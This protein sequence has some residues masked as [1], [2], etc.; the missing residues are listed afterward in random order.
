VKT[1]KK[2]GA[3]RFR[4]LVRVGKKKKNRRTVNGEKRKE[5]YGNKSWGH[6]IGVGWGSANH[7]KPDQGKELSS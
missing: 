4:P 7:S 3:G 5:R 1:G 6:I 2:E